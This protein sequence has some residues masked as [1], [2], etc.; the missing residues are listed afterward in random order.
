MYMFVAGLAICPVT[1]QIE[2]SAGTLTTTGEITLC[3]AEE[4][5]EFNISENVIPFGGGFGLFLQNTLGGPG[6]PEDAL[7]AF[8]LDSTNFTFDAG[9]NGIIDLFN[10]EPLNGLWVLKATAADANNIICFITQDSLIVNFIRDIPIIEGVVSNGFD[11]LT[12]NITGG[13]PPYEFLWS[14]GQTNQ[15]AVGLDS[16]EFGVTV[17]DANGCSAEGESTIAVSTNSI[18]TLNSHS[19]V[20]NPSN[21]SFTVQ[22]DFNKSELVVVEVL[23]ITGTL[24]AKTN[25][26][27][28]VGEFD[29][30]LADFSAGLYFVRITVDSE[31]LTQRI[32]VNK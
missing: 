30:N 6:G 18:S 19:I 15:T 8:R 7:I 29:F 13:L 5:F 27:L 26:K 9:L 21:G 1:G 24:I 22:L 17:I 32:V 12:V 20:P 14:N 28:T 25:R 11:E 2:C 10:F 16:G 3:G 31:S 4:T 23:D